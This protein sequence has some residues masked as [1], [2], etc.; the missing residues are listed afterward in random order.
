V[1]EEIRR[2]ERALDRYYQA[3]E[4]GDLDAGRLQTRLAELEARLA[5]LRDQRRG[6][7]KELRINGRSEILPTYRVVTPEV[8]ATTSSVG[9]AGIEPATP[10][11]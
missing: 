7:I 9:A 8:C 11:V 4:N 1:S 10:R 6:L 5:S 2:G 3:F